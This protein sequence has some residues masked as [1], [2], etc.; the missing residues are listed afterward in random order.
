M[1]SD[2]DSNLSGYSQYVYGGNSW[3]GGGSTQRP[4]RIIA[5]ARDAITKFIGYNRLDESGCL[6]RCLDMLGYK[7]NRI[8]AIRNIQMVTKGDN[9][10]AGEHTAEYQEGLNLINTLLA[11]KRPVVVGI[12]YSS[13][14]TG[15]TINEGITDHFVVIVSKETRLI[16]GKETEVYRY[17]DPITSNTNLG[18]H[19]D[20]YLY[21]K[22]N[23][24]VGV[25]KHHSKNPNLPYTVT[26]VREYKKP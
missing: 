4:N 11:Q 7:N 6:R 25:Y 8:G 15:E 13:S 17:Y 1:N 24:L 2:P 21:L 26:Q 22:D 20:N 9:G 5:D 10:R 14:R 3:G 12:D 18:T 19:D 16:D 23:K